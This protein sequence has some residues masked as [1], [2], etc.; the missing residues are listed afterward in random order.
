[1]PA[2]ATTDLVPGIREILTTHGRLAADQLGEA[3]DLYAS[4]L[5]SLATVAVMLALEDKFDVEFPENMMGRKTFRSIESIAE[6]ISELA[7]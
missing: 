1:M 3:D 7:A 4:G 5:T 2:T 6:A